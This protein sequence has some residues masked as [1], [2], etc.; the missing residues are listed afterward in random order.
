MKY[1]SIKQR[2]KEFL[3][4]QTNPIE[5][6]EWFVDLLYSFVLCL[7]F[8]MVD[9]EVVRTFQGLETV[10]QIYKWHMII[11]SMEF[12]APILLAYLQKRLIPLVCWIYFSTG[13][14]DTFFYLLQFGRL[15]TKYFGMKLFGL[16]WEPQP[17]VV[18]VV[19]FLGF[20]IML[21]YLAILNRIS[22]GG[23]IRN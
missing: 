22:T 3:D 16:F 8:T 2:I 7:A 13:L 15:P 17:N 18:L 20:V 4:Y 1:T 11:Y 21:M 10:A 14:E 6:V 9:V 23:I 19:N 5:P 12:I